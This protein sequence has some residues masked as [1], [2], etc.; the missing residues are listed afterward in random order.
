MD[1]TNRFISQEPPSS[2]TPPAAHPLRSRHSQPLAV[3]VVSLVLNSLVDLPRLDAGEVHPTDELDLPFHV[4]PAEL[5]LLL[6]MAGALMLSSARVWSVVRETHPLPGR[7]GRADAAT[8]GCTRR[9][10]GRR[11]KR[12]SAKV[13]DMV[14]NVWKRW[15]G[16]PV[17][18]Q[19][20]NAVATDSG[21]CQPQHVGR[22][23]A[24]T[25]VAT[26]QAL[27]T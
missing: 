20:Q 6:D 12:R 26:S 7:S 9:R 1:C 14:I 18:T 2:Y 4:L 8:D 21:C 13:P 15:V 24:G 10:G 19:D 5:V 3:A 22:D 25:L 27:S 11:T 23:R 17:A 16:N